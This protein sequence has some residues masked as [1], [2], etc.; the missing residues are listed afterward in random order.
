MNEKL[1]PLKIFI[2]I[3]ALID[4]VLCSPFLFL[5]F[6]IKLF[7]RA[8]SKGKQMEYYQD[9]LENGTMLFQG[10]F[11]ATN[12]PDSTAGKPESTSGNPDNFKS[13]VYHTRPVVTF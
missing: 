8:G 5:Y 2:G 7:I 3:G 11:T 13:S 10:P 4:C 12:D 6:T 9:T 1:T